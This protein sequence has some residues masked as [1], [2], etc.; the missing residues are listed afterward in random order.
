M[1]G[2]W[3]PWRLLSP[4][5]LELGTVVIILRLTLQVRLLSQC[6]GCISTKAL[7]EWCEATDVFCTLSCLYSTSAA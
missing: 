1:R 2:T 5:A 4:L 3:V 7:D 6:L